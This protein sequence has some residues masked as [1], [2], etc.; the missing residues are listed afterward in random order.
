MNIVVDDAHLGFRGTFVPKDEK[1][2][3]YVTLD[4]RLRV[5]N[6][7]EVKVAGVD[8]ITITTEM[9]NAIGD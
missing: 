6:G 5:V 9:Q 3:E 1:D 8:C 4:K 7:D 2:L